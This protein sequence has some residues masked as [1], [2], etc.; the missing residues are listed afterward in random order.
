MNFEL[1][2][3]PQHIAIIMDGNGRWAQLKGLS[4]IEG[5]RRGMDRVD[6]IVAF[7]RE[8]GIRYLTLYAFSMENWGRPKVE[9]EALMFLLKEMLVT[10][11]EKLSKNEV[12]LVA[13]GDLERLPPDV[14]Q[15]LRETEEMTQQFNKLVLNLALSYSGRDEIIRAVNC[16]LKEKETGR[17]RDSFISVDRFSDYLDTAG[18][19]DPDLVIRTSGEFRLSNFLL[20]QSAYSELYFTDTP[21]PDFGREALTA[22]LEEY[23]RRERRF[24]RTSEQIHGGD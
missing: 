6:D 16:L 18:I 5:H 21:W 15:T 3:V 24:G 11:R 13:T 1:K 2:K 9:I 14:L 19:P 17:L 8:L 22:A 12:R 4:R 10:K 20:W 7:C 23:Q